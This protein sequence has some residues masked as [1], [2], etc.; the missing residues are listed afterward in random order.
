MPGS[1]SE[2]DLMKAEDIQPNE[3]KGINSFLKDSNHV[4]KPESDQMISD[5][6]YIIWLFSFLFYGT[7]NA[8]KVQFSFEGRF[9]TLSD[10]K[11]VRLIFRRTK[12]F[13]GQN[14]RHLQKISSLLSDIFCPIRYFQG[15]NPLRIKTKFN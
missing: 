14:F 15:K 10:K 2:N 13:S 7:L 1:V 3:M 4:D 8:L 6:M 9:C 12:L 5:G 11:N